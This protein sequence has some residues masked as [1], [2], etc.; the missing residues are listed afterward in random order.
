MNPG[1]SVLAGLFRGQ[2]PPFGSAPV[3]PQP[4]MSALMNRMGQAP[5]KE[6]PVFPTQNLKRL[7]KVVAAEPRPRLL[8]LGRLT[9][10]NIEFLIHK[11]FRV[12]V[13]DQ[14]R[15]L[16][17]PPKLSKGPRAK[18]PPPPSLLPPLEY[19]GE[20]FD[21][22][23]TWDLYD[24]LAINQAAALT[25]EIRRVLKPRGL[26]LALFQSDRNATEAIRYEIVDEDRLAYL[27]V[28]MNRTRRIYEN[29]D[30]ETLF[31]GLTIVNSCFLAN[32]VREVLVRRT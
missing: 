29:L 6:P 12:T 5:R 3:G 32:Q 16:P 4:T 1:F 13:D 26:L 25:S 24:F 19:E 22:V 15:V 31:N 23:F 14:F 10:R 11:N 28:P 9:D 20:Q 18:S 7:L 27:P 17:E 2:P 8:D 21:V 30:I